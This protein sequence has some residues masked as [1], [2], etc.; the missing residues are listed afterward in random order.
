MEFYITPSSYST[1][2]RAPS[3]SSSTAF[4]TMRSGRSTG[5]CC[6]LC[7]FPATHW[8]PPV[9]SGVN[10]KGPRTTNYG[11]KQP[12]H[13]HDKGS[14]DVL[15]DGDEES[16]LSSLMK[17]TACLITFELDQPHQRT[18]LNGLLALNENLVCK[19]V[20]KT[21]TSSSISI[22][23]QNL[24][25]QILMVGPD[26]AL[27][28]IQTLTTSSASLDIDL[29]G[30]SKETNGPIYVAFLSYTSLNNVLKQTFSDSFMDCNKTI[31]STVVSTIATDY[32]DFQIPVNFTLKHI[33]ETKGL[34]PEGILSCAQRKWLLW[35]VGGCRVTQTNSTH[36]VC[37]CDQLETLA[38]FMLT[39]PCKV[40][41]PKSTL[42][43]VSW[44]N[45]RWVEDGCDIIETNISHTVCSCNQLG[46]FALIMETGLCMNNLTVL[47][48]ENLLNKDLYNTAPEF[49]QKNLLETR[50]NPGEVLSWTW[51]TGIGYLIPLGV[52]GMSGVCFPKGYVDEE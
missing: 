9:L 47:C 14:Y 13:Q 23:A 43:C 4:S 31:M 22:Y 38:L 25:V 40:L 30:I 42:F 24:E 17:L 46:T 10:L 39:I 15:L 20:K 35:D 50:S 12:K 36:T 45:T 2:S 28:D 18:F 51:L 26:I 29:I 34:D 27:T 37:S 3:S 32:F 19:M 21:S 41:A 16:Y 11:P 33:N 44:E 5:K 52:L 49:P 1:P 8:Q 7:A 48:T 6:V